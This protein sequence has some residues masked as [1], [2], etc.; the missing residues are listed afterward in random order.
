[1]SFLGDDMIVISFVTR[2]APVALPRRSQTDESLPFRLHAVFI[3]TRT[4]RVQTTREW[5]TPSVRSRVLAAPGRKF[6]VLTPDQLLLYSPELDL[7][8]KLDI[9]LGRESVKDHWHA[10]PSP[11]G[12]YLLLEYEPET[13]EKRFA[14]LP[15][16]AYETLESEEHIEWINLENLDVVERW[17]TKICVHCT[18]PGPISD[19]GMM[20]NYR[21]SDSKDEAPPN[22]T[23]VNIGRPPNGPWHL[24]CSSSDSHCGPGQFVNNE[25]IL[26]M[27]LTGQDKNVKLWI[28][29][30]SIRGELLFQ[31]TFP[32]GEIQREALCRSKHLLS[33]F[34]G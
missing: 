8:G 29:L 27:Q 11:G 21:L 14:G 16:S 18:W 12:R 30:I 3:D 24:M 28:G 31:Q 15:A 23:I 32:K 33:G 22:S 2:E 17:T 26:R 5:P 20:Q 6:V 7:L 34:L 13:D 9:P 19:E 1:M 10:G 25:A 4:G